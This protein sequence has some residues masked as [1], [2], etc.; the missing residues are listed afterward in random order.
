MDNVEKL[1]TQVTQNE[2]K[3]MRWTPLC[4]TTIFFYN[5]VSINIYYALVFGP[6]LGQYCLNEIY[7]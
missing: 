2:E 6:F 1:A 3:Q 7:N 4:I 5:I